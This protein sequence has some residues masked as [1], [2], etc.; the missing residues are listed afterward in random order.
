MVDACSSDRE[1]RVSKGRYFT[2]M[3]RF[4]IERKELVRV[5][6]SPPWRDS[7]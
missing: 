4:S 3:E 1:E 5:G 6:I 7:P 2:T